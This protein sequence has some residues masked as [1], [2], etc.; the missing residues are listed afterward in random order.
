MRKIAAISSLVLLLSITGADADIVELPLAAE[1]RYDV[2]SPS[3]EMDFDL[4]VTFTEISN[5]Y[6]DWSGEITADLVIDSSPGSD[7]FPI[8]AGICAYLGPNPWP[9][10]AWIY[11]G[12]ETY[13]EPELFDYRSEFALP[14]AT[15]WSDLLDGQGRIRIYLTGLFG[16]PG[17]SWLEFGYADLHSATLVVEGTIVPEPATILLLVAGIIG[18]RVSKR[19]S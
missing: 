16:P 2:N 8:D 13:P 11:G 7:P 6:M 9:R 12:A 15:T 1:G 10:G 19:R 18:V 3:W 14:G 17:V 5:V 4:G